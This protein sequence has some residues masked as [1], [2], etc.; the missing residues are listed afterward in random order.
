MV[1]TFIETC[2]VIVSKCGWLNAE[3][4]GRIQTTTS[5]CWKS[6]NKVPKSHC[7]TTKITLIS[8]RLVQQGTQR[9]ALTKFLSNAKKIFLLK[10]ENNIYSVSEQKDRNK[11][12]NIFVY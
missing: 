10:T 7:D 11:H 1:V 2:V 5:T 12:G 9:E 6:P 8:L 4:V 3:N